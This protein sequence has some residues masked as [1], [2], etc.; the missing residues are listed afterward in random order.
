MSRSSPTAGCAAA[1]SWPRRWPPART[2]LM[3]GSPLARAE[4]APGRGM[5]WGMAAPSP[6][7]PRGTRIKV[8]TV[9]SLERIL[10]GPAHVTDGSGSLVGALRQSMAALGAGRSARCSGSRWSTPRPP[11]PKGSPG[12]GAADRM[13]GHAV[14]T[15]FALV[16]L[17]AMVA[18]CTASPT[19]SGWTFGSGLPS[20]AVGGAVRLGR[21]P[22]AVGSTAAAASG[23]TAPASP[24]AS[25][26][27]RRRRAAA[28]GAPS[29]SPS[30]ANWTLRAIA[31]PARAR[32][33]S[34]SR[35]AVAE[36]PFRGGDRPDMG[37]HLRDPPR[38]KGTQ[39][40]LR[41]DHRR[42]GL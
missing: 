40:D 1:V 24:A 2:S 20:F 26:R 32:P 30:A 39:G 12:S 6:T 38:D 23:S 41:R 34:A 25:A 9:G 3:I 22:G 18:A 27:A 36:G 14:R 28:S 31:G 16:A 4:E 11:R 33:S 37:G 8:G 7:L 42:P 35:L 13:R 21:R 10:L 15:S 19:A 17:V 29:S 5:N